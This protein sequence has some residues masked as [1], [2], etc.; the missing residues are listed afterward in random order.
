MSRQVDREVSALGGVMR[1]T[2]VEFE[3]LLPHQRPRQARARIRYRVNWQRLCA[4]CL[5]AAIASFA[6][7]HFVLNAPLSEEQAFANSCRQLQGIVLRDRD[8]TVMDNKLICL[9]REALL[10]W[11]PYR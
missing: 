6:S 11:K 8:G 7:I 2:T 1:E 5:L 10:G 4:A 3:H 9:R